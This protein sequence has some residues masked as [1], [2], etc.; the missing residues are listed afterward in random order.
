[1]AWGTYLLRSSLV[2]VFIRFRVRARHHGKLCESVLLHSETLFSF[3][4]F[5]FGMCVFLQQ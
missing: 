4:D 2:L 1:M 5:S 3:Q